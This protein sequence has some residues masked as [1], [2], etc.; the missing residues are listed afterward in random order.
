MSETY[1][2]VGSAEADPASGKI[3]NVSPVGRALL[4]ARAGDTVTAQLPGGS[5]VFEVR[6]VR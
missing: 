3:S 1:L 4:G 2:L 5:I 6:E